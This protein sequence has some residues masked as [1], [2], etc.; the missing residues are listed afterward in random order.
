M[1]KN[2][3]KSGE[4]TWHAP[5]EHPKSTGKPAARS[6]HTLACASE[7][8][9]LFGGCGIEDGG[10]AVFNDLWIL[11]IADNFKWEKVD[12]MGEVPSPRW[13]HS[14]T[15]L[16]DNVTIFLF[17]GLCRVRLQGL[18]SSKT[19]ALIDVGS[20]NAAAKCTL[21]PADAPPPP[22]CCM[23]YLLTTAHALIPDCC[24]YR[25]NASTTA[26]STT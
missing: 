26:T 9:Y 17:G 21:L 6:G 16:P 12:A 1:V 15:F 22:R 25:A 13:R 10:A 23:R 5:K 14:F 4:M 20:R 8:A 11:H 3:A 24:A 19:P 18:S 2:E 7:K